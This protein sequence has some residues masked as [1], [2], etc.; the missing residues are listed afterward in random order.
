LN[1][2]GGFSII[3]NGESC[4]VPESCKRL[5]VFLALQESPQRRPVVA[6]T[7]WPNKPES[8]ASAN[9]RSSLWRLP[10][11]S[12]FPLVNAAG[13]T[14]QLSE[15]LHVDARMA[16]A[17]G[18]ALI[19]APSAIV[20]DVDPMLFFQ[21]LLP[22]WYEDWVV[23]ERERLAQLQ[24]HFLEALTYILIERERIVE[25]LDVALRLVNTDPLREGSQRALLAVYCTDRNITQAHR[26]FNR[27]QQLIHRTF[28]CEPSPSLHAMI[29]AA[30]LQNGPSDRLQ[31][32][33]NDREHLARSRG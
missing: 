3:V 17:T 19:R 2:L 5:L 8:R 9:L 24:L 22:G 26:Q 18:W 4:E 30:A 32:M 21:E 16:E 15:H 20:D 23:F 12:G 29:T 33:L 14:I 11:P 27:Y 13:A 7:L 28:G 25:A 10:E 1:L 31:P 6:G